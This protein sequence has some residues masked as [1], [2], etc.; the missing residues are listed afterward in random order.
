MS[1]PTP[2]L[3]SGSHF[4][5]SS[6]PFDFTARTRIVFGAGAI[7]QLGQLARENGGT[8]VLLVTDAGIAKAGHADKARASLEA[9]GLKVAVFDGSEQNPTTRCV[10]RALEVAQQN[11]IDFLVG[12]GGGSSMD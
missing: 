1:A 3:P 12:V 4:I 7:S 10:G 5:G 11:A 6:A 9:A 8:R 2:Y